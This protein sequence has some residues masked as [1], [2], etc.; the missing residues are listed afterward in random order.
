M[1]FMSKSRDKIEKKQ[2]EKEGEEYFGNL[3]KSHLKKTTAKFVMEPSYVFCENL[4]NGRLS[5]RGM[6][7]EIEK[8]MEAR[9]KD[10]QDQIEAKKETDVSDEQMAIQWQ[11]MQAKFNVTKKK[12][13]REMNISEIDIPT[14]KPKFLKPVD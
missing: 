9:M 4:V 12:R 14:K 13:H 2:F 6:N 5:F 7:P 3:F 10:I 8:L 11:K 1:K